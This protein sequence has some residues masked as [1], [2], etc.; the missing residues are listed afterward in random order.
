[1]AIN[2][3]N[4]G[5]AM[6]LQWLTGKTLLLH[7]YK[8]ELDTRRYDLT[9]KDIQENDEEGYAA[10]EM[11]PEGWK[12]CTNLQGITM[13][14]YDPVV[15]DF[16]VPVEKSYGYYVTDEKNERLLWIEQFEA[17]GFYKLPLRGGQIMVDTR[18][19]LA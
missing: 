2:L 10:L 12:V 17:G 18:L 9:I 11:K 1:M 6:F 4:E 8:N 7:L 13:A 15:F 3:T 14:A 16:V 19:L 5:K